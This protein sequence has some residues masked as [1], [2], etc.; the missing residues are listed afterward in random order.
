MIDA[1]AQT[2]FFDLDKLDSV[3]FRS[4][5]GNKKVLVVGEMH[6]TVE[7]PGMV[8]KLI[9]QLHKDHQPVTVGLEIPSDHQQ[10]VETFLKKGDFAELLKLAYFQYPDGRTS[11]AM[12]QLIQ[13]L[14]DLKDIR[15]ICFDADSRLKPSVNRDSVMGV[16]LSTGYRDGYLVLLTG[17]LHANLKEGYWRPN[18]K[19]AV[20]HFNKSRKLEGQLL[21][22][23]TYFGSG[24]IWNCMQDGCREREAQDNSSMKTGIKYRNFI[25]VFDAALAGGYHGVMYIDRVTAS[26]PLVTPAK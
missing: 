8:L 16:N 1:H 21:S 2:K 17:N 12:G 11:V 3:D 15:V 19:S 23:N 7:V 26:P 20:Y 18:F 9:Q 4:F 6:G 14:R 5:M 25:A 24:T 13:G 10:A 22:L